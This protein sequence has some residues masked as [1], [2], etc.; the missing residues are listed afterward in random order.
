MRKPVRNPLI[1]VTVGV[2]GLVAVY[3]GQDIPNRH[4]IE[5]ELTQRSQSALVAGGIQG[6]RVSFTGRDGTVYVLTAADLSR[7]KAIV[8]AQNGVRVVTV[9][10]PGVSAG[11]QPTP[12]QA[13]TEP[14]AQAPTASP[15]PTE[16][17][18][19]SPTPSSST[20]IQKLLGALPDVAFDNN[21]A[22]LTPQGLSSVSA[23]AQILKQNLAV[24]IAINGYTDNTGSAGNNQRLSQARA[25]SVRNQLIS[26]G[27]TADRL[28]AQGFG[29]SNP[30]VPNT[31][32]ANRA[33]N[34]R[35]EFVVQK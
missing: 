29:E 8:L 7:A 11:Q 10:A 34:R 12:T 18:T 17:P 22:T 9:I 33:I 30:K 27:I 5:H 15:T 20:D 13:P 21:K 16:S 1:G 31:S 2:V 35:V 3:L 14:P 25:N 23:V 28:T 4:H 6:A 32:A 26:L 19:P 24:K